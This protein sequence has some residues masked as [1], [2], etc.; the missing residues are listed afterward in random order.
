MINRMNNKI[1]TIYLQNFRDNILEIQKQALGKKICLAVKAD[2]YGHGALKIAKEAV[3]LGLD[4]LAV[5]TVEEAVFLRHN[6]IHIP[7]LVLSI[8]DESEYKNLILHNLS[9]VVEN[10]EQVKALSASANALGKKLGV[11]LKINTGMGRVGCKV[12]DALPLA[13]CIKEMDMLRLEGVCTHLSV[14]DSLLPEDIAFT[15]KQ[16]RLF[17]DSIK[18]LEQEGIEPG[19]RH[20][21][22][23]GAIFLH[24]DAHFDMVR[25]GISAYG[26]YASA[27]LKDFCEQKNNCLKPVMELKS[28]LVK[29]FPLSKGDSV[30][31]GRTW[32]AAE[33]TFIGL[34]PMGY[35]DGIR[36]CLSPG[37]DVKINE[38][39]YPIVGRI[40]M[41]QLML[42]L[43]KNHSC[44]AGD[45]VVFFGP[46]GGNTAD[47]L[48]K[49]C[50]TISYELL[51]GIGKRVEKMYLD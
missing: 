1:A 18:I 20:C 51:C 49:L 17:E 15:K 16:I 41:D 13:Q 43:G 37:L 48:A 44:S 42:D 26:Y 36:R 10:F 19:L 30:S 31:Y 27:E 14:S 33:D 39:F 47:D 50:K 32:T 8:I 22:N 25:P 11:H 5:S 21:A 9:L 6:D 45:E 2:A 12:S 34:V 3:K 29:I 4:Y 35:E 7:I 23:S 46:N 40:C 28:K 38:T 24:P